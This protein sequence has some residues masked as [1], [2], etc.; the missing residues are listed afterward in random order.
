MSTRAAEA[1]PA[2]APAPDA[3]LL[4]AL[5]SVVDP[6]LGIDIVSLGLV[7]EAARQG[8]CARVVLTMTSPA[9]P[10]GEV[11]VED[12]RAAVAASVAGLRQVDV[13]LVFEPRWTPERMS[14]EARRQLGHE[15]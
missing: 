7:Y 2:P 1:P 15:D 9:C 13:E 4:A 14:A 3:A 11:I 10:L 12:A 5:S 8:D 6:E